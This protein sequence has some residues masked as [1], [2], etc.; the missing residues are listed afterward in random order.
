[1]TPHLSD[2]GVVRCTRIVE[3]T[4]SA[5]FTGLAEEARLLL[6][7]LAVLSPV[8][9]VA[10]L[11][12]ARGGRSRD[13]GNVIGDLVSECRKLKTANGKKRQGRALM[14]MRKMAIRKRM[15]ELFTIFWGRPS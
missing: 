6:H 15:P 12:M 5:D 9:F 14:G 13:L 11:H 10:V 8:E 2:R 3:R 7:E 1:M 4:P